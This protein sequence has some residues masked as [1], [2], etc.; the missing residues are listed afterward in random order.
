MDPLTQ[1][2]LG[3]ALP[4]STRGK[5]QTK[6]AGAIGFLAGMAADLDVLIRSS[7]DSLLF[8]EYHR[9]FTHSLIFIPIGGLLVATLFFLVIRWW[10]R[11][12]FLR[13]WAFSSLGYATHGLLDAATSYG[14]Q[15]LWPISDRRFSFSIVSVVD[16]LF[17]L[18]L[19]FLVVVGVARKSGR[20]AR[21]ALV[22]GAAYLGFGAYQ[23]HAAKSLAYALAQA[24]GHSAVRLE[25]K[26]TFANLIVWRSIYQAEGQFY[27]DAVRPSFGAATFDGSSIAKLD[28][29]TALPWL[30]P[31][32]QQARDV[33][34]F[35]RFSDG[36]VALATD[37]SARIVD[38]RYAFLP[39]EITPLWSIRLDDSAPPTAHAHY[40]THRENA[41]ESLGALWA[42]VL[43]AK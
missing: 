23:H 8:L 11:V 22:W 4:L 29:A 15:L 10:L 39:T 3:A 17:T 30:D 24:R 33:E 35:E 41:R 21:L 37:G 43:K 6:I 42:M 26:P 14:T 19:L 40:E 32:S 20:W 13:L 27:V 28:V 31:E 34:R 16:P 12:D 1:G 2:A 9:Q 36:F 38:V 25:V 7:S 5:S 18:P